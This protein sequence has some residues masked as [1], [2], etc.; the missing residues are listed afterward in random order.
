MKIIK[1]VDVLNL[2]H[3]FANPALAYKW[4]NVGLQLGSAEQP[5]DKILLT[6]DVTENAIAMAVENNYDLIVSH[7]P[8][9]FKAVKK[10]C[11]PRFVTLIKNDISVIASH[12]NLDVVKGGV[13]TVLANRLGLKSHQFLSTSLDSELYRFVIYVPAEN[14]DKVAEAAF[15]AG[16]GIM[17]NYK[18]CMNYSY[19]QGQFTPQADS[20]PVVGKNGE[21]ETITELMMEFQ[22]ESF[23]LN[24]LLREVKKAHI[25]ETPA[26]Y[27][28]PLKQDS[29]NYGLG[30]IGELD[31][32]ISLRHFAEFVKKELNAPNVKLWPGNKTPDKM[33]KKIAVCGGSGSSLL[34]Q[35]HGRAD[36]LVSADFTYHTILDSKVPIID[37][38]HFHTEYPV[39]DILC[40]LLKP[41][42]VTVDI[43]KMDNHEIT[44][45]EYI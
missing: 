39:L 17:D 5:V 20:N 1:V 28:Y 23:K 24:K 7:H 33:V 34:S 30:L 6:L 43:M 37:A 12:T 8:F 31:E 44:K 35:V 42:D 22:V 27:V 11:D 41:L 26:Y 38:G 10:I 29:P 25:Y 40:N 15:R 4:D 19:V 13:N 16:A 21:K 9:I 36:V 32:E 14:A 45:L 18:D 3:S 2:I